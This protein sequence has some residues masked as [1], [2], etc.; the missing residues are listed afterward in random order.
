LQARRWKASKQQRREPDAASTE[1]A[2]SCQQAA[3]R[4]SYGY[5]CKN[6]RGRQRIPTTKNLELEPLS[7]EDRYQPLTLSGTTLPQPA[8]AQLICVAL[9]L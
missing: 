7:K 1:A 5:L 3:T 4:G 2:A 6:I 9:G 8:F